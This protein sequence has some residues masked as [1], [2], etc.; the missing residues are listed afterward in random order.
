MAQRKPNV[1][2]NHITITEISDDKCPANQRDTFF[3]VACKDS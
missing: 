3:C 2:K 1:D